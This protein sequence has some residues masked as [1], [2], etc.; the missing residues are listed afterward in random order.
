M[1][2]SCLAGITSYSGGCSNVVCTASTSLINST[3]NIPSNYSAYKL[4]NGSNKV[5]LNYATSAIS[6]ANNSIICDNQNGY[7]GT[8]AY[9]C[10]SNGNLTLSGCSLNKCQINPTTGYDITS[11]I[12]IDHNTSSNSITCATG[13]YQNS[14]SNIYNCQNNN[15]NGSVVNITPN[16]CSINICQLNP[17]TGYNI[18]S[19]I[20]LNYNQTSS[21]ITCATNYNG[22]ATSYSCNN[23][24][25]DGS[26][27]NINP[28]HCSINRC[29][30]SLQNGSTTASFYDHNTLLSVILPN[31][32]CNSGYVKPTLTGNLNCA[33]NGSI[34]QLV[35]VKMKHFVLQTL[36]ILT[37]P[38]PTGALIN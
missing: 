16:H 22:T 12:N 11:I 38:S 23:T 9:T 10:N 4:N 2:A 6:I 15:L 14:N 3:I 36:A 34:V 32:S 19:P 28:A 26:I 21:N 1:Q 17:K 30:A 7:G 20:V 25:T 37:A 13:Y 29:K 27:I 5:S 31:L 8:P 18:D 35:Y 33:T 24:N